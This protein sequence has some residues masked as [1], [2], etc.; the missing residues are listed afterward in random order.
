V[1][2]LRNRFLSVIGSRTLGFVRR[3]NV[4]FFLATARLFCL[5]FT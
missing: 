4:R 5:C 2:P 3:R 1:S